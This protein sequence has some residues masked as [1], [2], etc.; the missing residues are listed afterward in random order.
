[1]KSFWGNRYSLTN[2]KDFVCNEFSD[3][4]NHFDC[5]E[6]LNKRLSTDFSKKR[7]R[8]LLIREKST[9]FVFRDWKV[10]E[11]SEF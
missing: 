10:N 3:Y 5:N 6:L 8:F 9:I 1:M 4:V 7:E 2:S 11:K